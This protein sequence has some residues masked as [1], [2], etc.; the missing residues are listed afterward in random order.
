MGMGR[1]TLKSGGNIP[2]GMIRP[3]YLGAVPDFFPED[4]FR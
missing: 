2:N 1:E 4:W 3:H